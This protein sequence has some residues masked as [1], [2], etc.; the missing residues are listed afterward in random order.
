MDARANAQAAVTTALNKGAD[1]AVSIS[2]PA[3]LKHIEQTRRSRP[4]ATPEEVVKILGRRFTAAVTTSGTVSGATAAAPAVGLPVSLTLAALDAGTFTAAAGLYV[5]ALSEVYGVPVDDLERRRTLLL[6]VLLGD[7]GSSAIQKA[8]GRTGP[9]WA[10]KVV[11][12]IPMESI[13][14]VNKVLGHN[15]VTKY[16]TRQGILVLGKQVPFGIGG[17][18]G[19]GGNAVFAR[20]TI[21]AAKRAFGA[22]PEV[23]PEHL[24][25]G[26][27]SAPV[28]AEYARTDGDGGGNA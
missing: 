11:T 20:V 6:G 4:D 26:A 8:A 5:L 22:A 27:Y 7:A 10:R 19:G 15:F 3:V 14:A 2:R 9:H 28:V 13:R 1:K 18:I 25:G 24:H 16:G 21:K 23:W 17:V 12:A